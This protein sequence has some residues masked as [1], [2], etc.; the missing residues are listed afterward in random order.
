M[1]EMCIRDRSGTPSILNDKTEMRVTV[2]LNDIDGWN[3]IDEAYWE[4]DDTAI[5]HWTDTGSS[6]YQVRLY[7][8]GTAKTS[9]T[10]VH[11]NV[12][13]L[14]LIHIFPLKS[15]ILNLRSILLSGNLLLHR[16]L[17]HASIGHGNSFLRPIGRP[18]TGF[19]QLVRLRGN[20]IFLLLVLRRIGES[21]DA[22][23]DLHEL[24]AGDGLLLDEEGS[25]GVELSLI[26]IFFPLL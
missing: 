24:L 12:Y 13:N 23:E 21:L 5:A 7:R 16:Q 11:N 3:D 6:K 2:Q 18:G 17:D 1:P 15:D 10:T 8:N 26:H 19:L 25:D 22:A 9:A 4:N 14:S 20:A